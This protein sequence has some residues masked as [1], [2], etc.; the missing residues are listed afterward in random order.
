METI[1]L[2]HTLIGCFIGILLII[3]GSLRLIALLVI[4]RLTKLETRSFETIFHEK[5]DVSIRNFI[6][7]AIGFV[8][9]GIVI[10]YF[11]I[12]LY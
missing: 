7:E 1:D 12:R 3:K 8:I 11:V 2:I 6:I 9:V 10:I 5:W 4:H